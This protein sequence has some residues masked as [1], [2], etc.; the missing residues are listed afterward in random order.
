MGLLVIY[1]SC[2]DYGNIQACCVPLLIPAPP[3]VSLCLDAAVC[4]YV[5]DQGDI[6]TYKLRNIILYTFSSFKMAALYLLIYERAW[7]QFAALGSVLKSSQE[8]HLLGL[9]VL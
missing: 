4:S 6:T 9:D 8:Q 3:L 1:Q 5:I 2:L 7:W